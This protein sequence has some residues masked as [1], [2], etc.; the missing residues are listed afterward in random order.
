MG[1]TRVEELAEFDR[2][3]EEY[4]AT[5]PPQSG[6]VCP[7]CEDPILLT[8]EVYQLSMVYVQLEDGRLSF[9]TAE[10]SDH[11]Y[12][13]E[14]LFVCLSCWESII[15]D[16]ESQMENVPPVLDPGVSSCAAIDA[17]TASTCSCSRHKTRGRS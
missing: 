4:A 9:T 17:Q 1:E 2:A 12:L 14:P 11:D 5:G 6:Q 16:L 15:D 7:W 8:E 10:D 3:Y 13:Y